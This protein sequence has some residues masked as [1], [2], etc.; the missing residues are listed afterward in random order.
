MPDSGATLIE[1]GFLSPDG[2]AR[3]TRRGSAD[4]YIVQN[5]EYPDNH[6]VSLAFELDDFDASNKTYGEPLVLMA[7][8][9][10]EFLGTHQDYFTPKAPLWE[11]PLELARLAPKDCGLLPV[12]R[13]AERLKTMPPEKRVV[14]TLAVLEECIA[15]YRIR[16]AK[17]AEK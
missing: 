6:F 16:R 7:H 12:V 1:S 2:F 8:H 5:Q 3:I 9:G 10:L 17:L 4:I 13:A 15:D 14:Q 11:L